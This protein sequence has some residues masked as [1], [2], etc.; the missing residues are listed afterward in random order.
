VEVN[1][2]DRSFVFFTAEWNRLQVGEP[3]GV[4]L[5]TLEIPR[6]FWKTPGSPREIGVGDPLVTFRYDQTWEFVDAIRNQR[7]CRPD[8]RDGARVQ[9]VMDAALMSAETRQWVSLESEK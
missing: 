3:G 1:G 6:E 8:F 7:P 4:G 5:K 2:S 9:A